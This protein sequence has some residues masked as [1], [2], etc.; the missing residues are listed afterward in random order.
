MNRTLSAVN[1]EHAPTDF[2]VSNP[3]IT[4]SFIAP[5]RSKIEPWGT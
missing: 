1:T 2:V 3:E 4:F 5:S